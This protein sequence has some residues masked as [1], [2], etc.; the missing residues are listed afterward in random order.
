MIAISTSQ[1]EA[2]IAIDIQGKKKLLSMDSNCKHSENILLNIDK[3]LDELGS[4]LSDNDCFAVVI[5]PG[6]FTGIRIGIALIKGLCSGIDRP[7]VP[8]YSFELLACSFQKHRPATDFYCVINGLSGLYFVQKFN[9]AAQPLSQPQILTQSELDQLD[10]AKVCY[11]EEGISGCNT[12][13][14]TPDELL[15]LALEKQAQGQQVAS[16]NILPFYMR[17]S[18]AEADLDAKESGKKN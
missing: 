15:G 8:I 7:V 3:M 1:K 13:T 4:Q 2:L 5:G 9:R 16:K 12:V 10:G 18:Q 11:A 17:K 6:S 14:P